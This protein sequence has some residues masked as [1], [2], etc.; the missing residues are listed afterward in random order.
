MRGMH[1][2]TLVIDRD[3]GGMLRGTALVPAGADVTIAGMIRGT[4]VVEAGARVRISGMVSGRVDNR[5]GAI[6]VTGML[7]A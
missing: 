3:F 2:G 7:R 1:T 4:L 6:D 5:G